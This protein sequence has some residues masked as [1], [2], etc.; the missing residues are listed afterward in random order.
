MCS[1]NCSQRLA[2]RAST[3][4]LR[5]RF[6]EQHCKLFHHRPFVWHIWDGNKN[7]F[8]CLV[9]AHKLTGPDGEGRRTLETIT[10]SYL[11]GWIDR[12]REDQKEGK[13]GSDG[14]LAAALELQ[15]QLK[16]DPRWRAALRPFHPLETA[17]RTA[18]QVGI[19]TLTMVYG[20]I[21]A[22]S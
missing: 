21:F 4:W 18:A 12:Q 17:P 19:P 7:G 5:N 22:R 20:S 8:Q 2:A 9:N 14:R 11:V 10:Y 16:E 13:E 15:D 3:A 1:P 6:F